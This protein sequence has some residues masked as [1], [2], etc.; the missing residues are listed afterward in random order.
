MPMYEYRC[1]DCSHTS[2]KIVRTEDR[3]T[4]LECSKCGSLAVRVTSLPAPP[5]FKGSGWTEKFHKKEG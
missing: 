2:E 5:Q 1:K 3:D 4:P